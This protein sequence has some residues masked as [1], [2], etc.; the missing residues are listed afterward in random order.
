M[1]E[2][3]EEFDPVIYGKLRSEFLKSLEIIPAIPDKN[4]EENEEEIRKKT[5]KEIKEGKLG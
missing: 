2:K 5:I 3:K 1:L 4:I